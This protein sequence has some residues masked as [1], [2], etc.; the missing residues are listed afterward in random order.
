[1]TW[2]ATLRGSGWILLAVGVRLLPAPFAD[3]GFVILAIYALSGR[4]RAVQAMAAS[5]FLTMINPGLVMSPVSPVGRYMVIASAALSVLL[6]SLQRRGSVSVRKPVLAAFLLGLF[7]VLHSLL[8]SP[9]VGI[10]LLKAVSWTVAV[11][12]AVAAWSGLS[13]ERAQ[14]LERWL[15]GSMAMVVLV[16][17]PLLASPVGFL[18]NGVGFQGVLNHPQALGVVVAFG[19]GWTL[20]RILGQTRPSWSLVLLSG[21]SI[22]MVLLSESR[23]G[24]L[25]MVLGLAVAIIAASPLAGR[26]LRQALPGIGSARVHA[27]VAIAVVLSLL[28]WPLVV[29]NVGGFL[30]KRSSAQT[31]SGLYDGSRGAL[32]DD[33]LSNIGEH[34]IRGIGFGVAST[35]GDMNVRY[36]RVFGLPVGAAVEKGVAPLAVVEELGVPGFVAVGLWLWMIIRRAALNG[37]ESLAVISVVLAVNLGESILFSPGGTGMLTL[38]LLGWCVRP[39]QGESNTVS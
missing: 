1:M 11:S 6:R 37:V 27:V 38:V 16:S 29:Q 25:G 4:T 7:L 13:E 36:D 5:W 12:T 19:G 2:L 39:M 22:V 32:I 20:A 24:G 10:S 35:P 33:M 21:V 17:L 14:A 34:P 30:T 18:R 31:L 28:V 9:M 23:T 26:P 15:F 8:V 3:Y